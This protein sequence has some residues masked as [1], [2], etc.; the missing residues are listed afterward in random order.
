VNA[1]LRQTDNI[2]PRRVRVEQIYNAA[3]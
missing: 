1:S 3:F 2:Q